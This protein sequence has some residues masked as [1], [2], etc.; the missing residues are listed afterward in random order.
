MKFV[1]DR[2]ERQVA[3]VPESEGD[4][5]EIEKLLAGGLRHGNAVNM[6]RIEGRLRVKPALGA[7]FLIFPLDNASAFQ[8]V[9]AIE[10]QGMATETVESQYLYQDNFVDGYG[11]AWENAL[12]F[13]CQSTQ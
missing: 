5:A 7:T 2:K 1:C 6:Y 12:I 13:Q 3:V 10:M 11:T 4:R 8:W 9:N